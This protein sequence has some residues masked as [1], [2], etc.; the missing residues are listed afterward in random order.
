MLQQALLSVGLP[1]LIATI[2][3]AVAWFPRGVREGWLGRFGPSLALG[4]AATTS[5]LA[6]S[7]WEIPPLAKWHVLPCV[8]ALATLAALIPALVR[9]HCRL[10]AA[11][12]VAGIAAGFMSFPGQ[13]MGVRC[14]V[15]GAAIIMT[16]TMGAAGRCCSWLPPLCTSAGLGALAIFSQE[17]PSMAA[18]AGSMAMACLAMA[19]LAKVCT[20]RRFPWAACAIAS[21]AAAGCAAC[22]HAYHE[23][24]VP[25]WAWIA[26]GLAPLASI[27]GMLVK[28]T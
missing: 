6:E 4:A 8:L 10:I 19:V 28:R 7:G 21:L 14:A 11:V 23:G 13:G 12:A 16:L 24:E 18:I 25:L 3:A 20:L 27:A 1:T 9:E 15:V 5:F 2:I 22:G 26:G 17:W